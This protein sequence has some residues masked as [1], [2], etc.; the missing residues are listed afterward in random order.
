[1]TGGVFQLLINFGPPFLTRTMFPK[2]RD[3]VEGPRLEVA[4]NF[5]GHLAD[6]ANGDYHDY[7]Q[8]GD[9]ASLVVVQSI[10]FKN[11]NVSN[12]SQESPR[13]NVDSPKAPGNRLC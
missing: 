4:M 9:V 3:D 6:E 12:S 2:V 11:V 8:V 7:R 10:G 13:F 5:A 1:M